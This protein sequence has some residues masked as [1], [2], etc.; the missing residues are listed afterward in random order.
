MATERLSLMI[1]V[2]ASP[3]LTAELEEAMCVAAMTTAG[4][5]KWIRVHPVAFRDL[6]TEDRFKKYQEVDLDVFRPKTD[7]RPESWS[8]I[9]GS[10]Q[11]GDVIGT[12]DNWSVRRHRVES[13]GEH[14]MCALWG[15]AAEQGQDATS[16]AVVRTRSTPE[17]VISE[18]DADQLTR[19]RAR[20]EAM[21]NQRSLF[22]DPDVIKQPAEVIPWRFQYRYYC[23]EEGCNGHTQTI[24]D[25]EIAT[26]WRNV[27]HS[28]DWREKIRAKF[29]DDLW[30][31][32][33]DSRLFVGNQAQHPRSFLVLGVFWPPDV[34]AQGVLL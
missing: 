16:L 22:D 21:A 9:H 24:V 1:L 14:T 19:W 28:P 17:L 15:S 18:R 13:L 2:K 11:L 3:V 12:R 25:W 7:R 30:A 8:P 10:L 20:A 31:S 5:P 26:L 34:P 32:N 27:R 23:L 29:V 4:D 33:R 6:D